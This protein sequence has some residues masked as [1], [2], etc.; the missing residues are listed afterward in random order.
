MNSLFLLL[1]AGLVFVFGYRFYAKLLALGVFRLDPNYSTPAHTLADG[2]DYSACNRH[3]AFGHHLAALA[4]ATTVVGGG[5]SL[6][7]GWIPAFLWVVA[8]TAVAA[9]A[10]GL[11]SLWL[12]ARHPGLGPAGLA[13]KIIGPRAADF[14][15][16]LGF[17]LLL[18]LNAACAGLAAKLMAAFPAAVLPFWSLIVVALALGALLH[19]RAGA[20]ILPAALAVLPLSLLLIWLLG[21]A[22]VAITG[23]VHLDLRGGPVLTLDAVFLWVVLLFAYG[24]HSARLPQ[25]V[26]ARPRGFLTALLL[27]ALLFAFYGGMVVEHPALVAP[28]FN[29][30]RAGPGV[31]PWLFVTLTSGALAGFHLLVANGVT[32]RQM[33]RETDARYIGYGAALVDGLIALSA[34]LIGAAAFDSAEEWNRFYASWENLKDPQKIL[35]LYLNGLTRY[36]TAIG[37]EAEFA[38]TAAATVMISLLVAT[39]EAGLRIQRQLLTGFVQRRRL[40]VLQKDRTLLWLA[41]GASAAFAL[42]DGRGLGWL[43]T[44]PVFGVAN[45]VLALAGLLLLVLALKRARRPVIHALVPLGVLAV[46]ANWGLAQLLA[47]WAAAESWG[48]FGLGLLLFIMECGIG[49]S[50][51]MRLRPTTPAA[52]KT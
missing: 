19:R 48:L 24:Y 14:F 5:I 3:L 27:G 41:V 18:I 25:H 34:I 36:A 51:L 39:L 12:S 40:A 42:H 22:P 33:E 11:G 13:A 43:G 26:L 50:A 52:P 10:Y 8:G 20:E 21:K 46:L 1:I 2:R 17:I 23:A 45:Q 37:V 29:A 47:E 28:E 16:V 15:F 49:A 44:W 30:P 35:L 7:W 38:R 9:G 4:A 32:A 6:I 31:A